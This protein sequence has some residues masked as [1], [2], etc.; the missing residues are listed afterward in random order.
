MI[1]Y[2]INVSVSCFSTC[3]HFFL[4]VIGTIIAFT[5]T[6]G[7]GATPV[8]DELGYEENQGVS[9]THTATFSYT[10]NL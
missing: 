1:L 8:Q 3:M 7:G 5:A 2:F 4:C 6:P 9:N 10:E